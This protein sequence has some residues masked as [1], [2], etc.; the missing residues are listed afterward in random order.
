MTG[1]MAAD[2]NGVLSIDKPVGPTS[3]DLVAA[4]R[5]ALR[6]RRVGHAGTLDPFASGVLLLCIGS[7]TRLVEYATALEKRYVAELTL[8]VATDTD[9]LTGAPLATSD[10]WRQVTAAQLADA[11]AAQQGSILQVPPQFSA[12]KVAGERS[13]RIARRGDTVVLPAVPVTIHSIALLAYAP[14]RATFEVT[15][16][17]GTYI[18]A[19]ARDAGATLGCG[20]HLSALRRTAIGGFRIEDALP[21]D[22]LAD[23]AAAALQ[24]PV[25]AVAHMQQ[26]TVDEAGAHRLRLG[27]ALPLP[28]GLVDGPV[29]VLSGGRLIAIA[30]AADAGLRPRKVLHDA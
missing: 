26:Y 12:K 23:G 27:Q 21:A 15:C 16:S 2:L 28:D 4:A 3:H 29:A 7:A 22:A 20:A 10:A 1:M 17:S 14:P 11:L 5:R 9:D 19:V 8:G 24:P 13:H 6:T 18:R 25:A 30:E